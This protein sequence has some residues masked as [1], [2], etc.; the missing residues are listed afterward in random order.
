MQGT[1]RGAFIEA[2][3][4]DGQSEAQRI[5]NLPF[6]SPERAAAEAAAKAAASVQAETG[7]TGRML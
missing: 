2:G 7:P 1:T 6:G 3:I 4:I 5:V